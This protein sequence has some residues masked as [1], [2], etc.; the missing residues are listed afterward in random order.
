MNLSI[1]CMHMET[2]AYDPCYSMHAYG[3][4]HTT[5]RAICFHTLIHNTY[6]YTVHLAH[7]TSMKN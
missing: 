1:W 7:T 5:I 4:N 6:I 3:H 2:P